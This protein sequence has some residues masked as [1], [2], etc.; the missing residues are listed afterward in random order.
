MSIQSRGRVWT[1]QPASPLRLGGSTLAQGIGLVLLPAHNGFDYINGKTFAKVSGATFGTTRA[2]GGS[3]SHKII[4][5]STDAWESS[6]ALGLGSS[7]TLAT[8]VVPETLGT[9]VSLFGIGNSASLP[10]RNRTGLRIGST[11]LAEAYAIGAT[12]TTGAAASSVS[13]TV[14]QPNVIVGLFSG[15]ASRR[16]ALNG[17]ISAA[18]TTS[19]TAAGINTTSIGS[20]A[21][22]SR[23][24]GQVGDYL[25][26]VAWSRVLSDAEVLDF[27]DNPWQIFRA[28]QRRYVL[29][30]NKVVTVPTGALTLTGFP[31]TVTVSANQTISVPAGT[32]ALTGLSPTVVASNHQ[33]VTVPLGTLNLTGFAPTVVVSANQT[34]TV[35]LGALTLTG[36]APTVIATANQSV[37]VPLG[38]LTLTGFAPVVQNGADQNIAVPLG[39][40]TLTGFAPSIVVTANQSVQVPVGALLLTGFAPTAVSTDNQRVTVPLGT[41]T[42]TGFAPTVQTGANKTVNVPVGSLT[43]TGFAPTVQVTANQLISVPLGTLNLT[44]FAPTVDN[45]SAASPFFG[46][47]NLGPSVRKKKRKPGPRPKTLR[48]QLEET[49]EQLAAK[50]PVSPAVASPA[51]SSAEK[52]ET[53][54]QPAPAPLA[55]LVAEPDEAAEDAQERQ[56][57][58]AAIQAAVDPL[59][60][61]LEELSTDVIAIRRE[62]DDLAAK[63]KQAQRRAQHTLLL[64]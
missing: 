11:G 18:E 9:T 44:G 13:P 37:A 26:A 36:L 10:T 20:M 55:K 52:S 54:I 47:G 21:G 32:L 5:S 39:T 34:V 25:L 42:L 1:R 46:Y 30:S 15:T 31:P 51:D 50:P 53:E 45:G 12:G 7:V 17:V 35:P 23:L 4:T 6:A 19:A 33:T 63:R 27:C 40:L 28:P 41:L 14:G 24:A 61:W 43:L 60:E 58:A 3:R 49:Y 48:E 59:R 62:L 56:D 22:S 38:S 2:Y 29:H 8:V 64:E 16:V 57:V